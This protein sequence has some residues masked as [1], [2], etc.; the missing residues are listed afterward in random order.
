MAAP[1]VTPAQHI[2]VDGTRQ[3]LPHARLARLILVALATTSAA[4]GATAAFSPGFFYDSVPG[5]DLL[6]PYN[7]HLLTD[8][9]AFYL[10]F[11]VLFGWGAVTL[12]RELVIA[13]CVAWTVVQILH[14]LYHAAHLERFGLA[15]AAVQTALLALLLIGPVAA[16]I[17]MRTNHRGADEGQ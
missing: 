17:A 10:G 15:D 12:G 7:N 3:S 5:V 14:F 16:A 4:I 1:T 6:P 13:T 2:E 8:V 9:G 11:A